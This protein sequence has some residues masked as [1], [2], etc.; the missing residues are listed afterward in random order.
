M[1]LIG[2]LSLAQAVRTACLTVALACSI[3]PVLANDEPRVPIDTLTKLVKDQIHGQCGSYVMSRQY[4][5]SRMEVDSAQAG[6]ELNCRC[7][8]VELDHAVAKL[9][10]GRS[11]QAVGKDEFL[12][13]MRNAMD[14]C[15]AH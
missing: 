6:V 14:A 15:G 12:S 7:L 10:D 1:R 3:A 5:K 13:A 9:M 8:P 4:A 11:E 2:T